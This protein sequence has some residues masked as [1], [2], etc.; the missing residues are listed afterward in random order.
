MTANLVTGNILH[1]KLETFDIK[2]QFWSIN[3]PYR[4]IAVNFEQPIDT[5]DQQIIRFEHLGEGK[6][7]NENYYYFPWP[8]YLD[9]SLVISNT[10]ALQI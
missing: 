10:S 7:N 1:T 5:F 6:N 4:L 3:N 9:K 8:D 2:Q